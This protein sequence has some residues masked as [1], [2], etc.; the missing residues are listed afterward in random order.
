VIQDDHQAQQ[1]PSRGSQPAETGFAAAQPDQKWLADPLA[2]HA[3]ACVTYIPTLEGWLYLATVLD[4]YARHIVGWAMAERMTGALTSKALKIA[5][6]QRK[7][8]A[9]LLHHSDQGSQYTDPKYR[10]LLEAHGTQASM[11][12]VGS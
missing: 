5:L 1:G 11:N 8:A 9:G 2:L 10:A 6:Q 12:G 4:L 3:S 7:P